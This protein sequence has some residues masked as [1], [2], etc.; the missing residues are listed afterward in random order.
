M[1]PLVPFLGIT[2]WLYLSEYEDTLGVMMLFASGD[3]LYL[4]VQ[5]IAPH[6]GMQR[7]WDRRWAL[8]ADSA[9]PYWARHWLTAFDRCPD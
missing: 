8:F 4:I 7:A 5:D 3:I 9:L 1:V 6:S 2:G